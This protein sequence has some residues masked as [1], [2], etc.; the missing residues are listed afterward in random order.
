M[1][2]KTD[3]ATAASTR[4]PN[5]AIFAKL[6]PLPLRVA[7]MATR[8][9]PPPRN[10][11]AMAGPW[12]V[13]VRPTFVFATRRQSASSR[14]AHVASSAPRTAA[15]A[16]SGATKGPASPGATLPR[17]YARHAGS[18]M[19]S[20][21]TITRSKTKSPCLRRMSRTA[22]AAAGSK[23]MSAGSATN[24]CRRRSATTLAT[25][26]RATAF[27]SSRTA[28]ATGSSTD[29]PS[30]LAS[31]SA[32]DDDESRSLASKAARCRHATCVSTA[33]SSK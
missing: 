18:L 23:A 3:D 29:A 4:A 25:G 5:L 28:S 24:A 2:E 30:E 1:P 8:E 14:D 9:P 20:S 31:E 15:A 7:A 10:L 6:R 32:S 26:S 27:A 22:A 21:G 12:I 19:R 13:F 16:A 11:S 17:K 33:S